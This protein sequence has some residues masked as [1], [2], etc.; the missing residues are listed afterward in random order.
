MLRIIQFRVLQIIENPDKKNQKISLI[1][2]FF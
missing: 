2:N 1:V